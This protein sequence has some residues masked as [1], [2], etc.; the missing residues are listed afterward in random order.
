MFSSYCCK[1][2]CPLHDN[3]QRD[4]LEAVDDDGHDDDD[5]E[6]DK[7]TCRVNVIRQWINLKKEKK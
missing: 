6:H 7:S 2:N 1:T 5:D 3:H 4:T